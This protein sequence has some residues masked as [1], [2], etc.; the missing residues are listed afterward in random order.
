MTTNVQHAPGPWKVLRYG[1]GL[2]EGPLRI[3]HINSWDGRRVAEIPLTGQRS[4]GEREANA[5][6]M[7]AAPELLAAAEEVLKAPQN[8]EA[9]SWP[10]QYEHL[11]GVVCIE[12]QARDQ[13]RAAIAK[14]RKGEA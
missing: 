3:V 12:R 2:R 5:L 13:L 4:E 7:A 10:S 9:C 6:L 14:A 1:N 8:C 11:A